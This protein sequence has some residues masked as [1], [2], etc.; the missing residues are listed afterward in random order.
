MRRAA[1]LAVAITLLLA[2]CNGDAKERKKQ[3]E[4][5]AALASIRA[6]LTTFRTRYG[7][8]P[9]S[10]NELVLTGTLRGL[11]RDPVTLSNSTW[12]PTTEE[13]VRPSSDFT[14]SNAPPAESVIIDVRSAAPGTDIDGKRWNSY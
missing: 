1:A 3:A 6:A 7:R 5:R 10:L 14:G 4:M 11:P 13:V 9:H 8:H 2:A 12:K